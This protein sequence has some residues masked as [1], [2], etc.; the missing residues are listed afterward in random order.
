MILPG[1]EFQSMEGFKGVI[2]FQIINT[3]WRICVIE[4]AKKNRRRTEG[5]R[6]GAGYWGNSKDSEKQQK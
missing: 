4:V 1:C 5:I 6:I 2:Q 3:D